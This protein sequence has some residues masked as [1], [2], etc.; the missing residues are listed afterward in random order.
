MS[1]GEGFEQQSHSCRS[2][3]HRDEMAISAA[4]LQERVTSDPLCAWL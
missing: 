4:Q 2:Q 1:G 3:S